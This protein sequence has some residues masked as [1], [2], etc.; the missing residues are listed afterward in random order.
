MMRMKVHATAKTKIM[1]EASV[2]ASLMCSSLV[3]LF[4]SMVN[5]VSTAATRLRK[6]AL[7]RCSILKKASTKAANTREKTARKPTSSSQQ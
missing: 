1:A 2:E 3:N 4:S 7:S 6:S 5:P